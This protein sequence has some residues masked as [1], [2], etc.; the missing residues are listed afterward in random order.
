MGI[1]PYVGLGVA[2]TSRK[3]GCLWRGFPEMTAEESNAGQ[4]EE[5]E[6]TDSARICEVNYT[7]HS[8]ETEKH[9]FTCLLSS[10]LLTYLLYSVS[11]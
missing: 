8:S 4:D 9:E 2:Q 11:Y 5:G 1:S 10:E 6:P 3:K 7:V